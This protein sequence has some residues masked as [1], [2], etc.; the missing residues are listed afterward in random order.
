MRRRKVL[1]DSGAKIATTAAQPTRAHPTSAVTVPL[2]ARSRTAETT[3]E[4]GL[5]ATKVPSQPGSDSTGTNALDRN[6]S[7]NRIMI[8]IPCTACALREIVPAH[9]KIHA[10][11]H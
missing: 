1:T 11:D 6:V 8:E 2:L 9:A 3:C 5:M 7:G 4:T 10:S